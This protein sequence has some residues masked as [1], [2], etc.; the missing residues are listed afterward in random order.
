[1]H[2]TCQE[3][4]IL[5]YANISEQKTVC[6]MPALNIY[7]TSPKFPTHPHCVLRNCFPPIEEGENVS[8]ASKAAAAA[9]PYYGL[10]LPAHN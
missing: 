8:V 7:S 6:Y 3:H 5:N 9:K 1:M 4:L 10:L 2:T